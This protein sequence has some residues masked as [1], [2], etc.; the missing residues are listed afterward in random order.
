[1]RLLNFE[2]CAFTFNFQF[3][4]IILFF[5]YNIQRARKI[6]R[7]PADNL[8]QA[9]S[10][11]LSLSFSLSLSCSFSILL[12]RLF[13]CP[14]PAHI[15]IL[16]ERPY[17]S[18]SPLLCAD[19]TWSDVPTV[20]K[21]RQKRGA[22]TRIQIDPFCRLARASIQRHLIYGAHTTTFLSPSRLPKNRP[23]FT[24]GYKGVVAFCGNNQQVVAKQGYE[25]ISTAVNTELHA[26]FSPAPFLFRTLVQRM[27]L[28]CP[29]RERR[30]DGECE[31]RK[32]E[33]RTRGT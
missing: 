7:E 26:V 6:I 16:H 22:F 3:C 24:H 10:L 20:K 15:R 27:P 14:L 18:P 11:G 5:F 30:R 29:D 2:D 21:R 4:R 1:M 12:P 19:V 31:G 25:C 32:D 8:T 13:N 9:F 28:L 33:G 23:R 17:I